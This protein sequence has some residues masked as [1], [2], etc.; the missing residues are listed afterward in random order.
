MQE[1]KYVWEASRMKNKDGVLDQDCWRLL[2]PVTSKYTPHQ[3]KQE[4][5]RRIKQSEYN[6]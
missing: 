4:C 5:A 3:G 1:S 2:W 6:N